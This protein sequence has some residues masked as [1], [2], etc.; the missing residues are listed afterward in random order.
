MPNTKLKE[1]VSSDDDSLELN[2]K[3]PGQK[4]SGLISSGGAVENQPAIQL[5]ER[6]RV[7]KPMDR[8]SERYK[9]SV[10]ALKKAHEAKALIRKAKEEE[11]AKL[12]AMFLAEQEKKKKEEEEL[13]LR[14]EK[15]RE[16][17]MIK[18]A[19]KQV[20]RKVRAVLKLEDERVKAVAS[21]KV[22][23]AVSSLEKEAPVSPEEPQQKNFV[24]VEGPRVPFSGLPEG[25]RSTLP[26]GRT[27]SVLQ[28]RSPRPLQAPQVPLTA[29]QRL[30]MMG[31]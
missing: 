15:E 16:A 3:Y 9:K 31:F 7:R 5:T 22:K 23:E 17:V 10:E 12:Q 29:R 21:S 11:L 24:R 26:E 18:Q 14:L 13:R 19:K 2:Q 20:N 30:A 1:V 8:D 4:I 28:A 25:S 6:G 27:H